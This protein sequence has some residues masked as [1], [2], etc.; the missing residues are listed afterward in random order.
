MAND[1]QLSGFKL[2][3]F[4]AESLSYL[5]EQLS[6]GNYYARSL[7]RLPFEEGMVLSNLPGILS[8]EEARDFNSSLFLRTNL[9]A[10]KASQTWLVSLIS[11]YL[12]GRDSSFAIFETLLEEGDKALIS[13]Q[14]HLFSHEK[15]IYLYLSESSPEIVLETLRHARGFPFVGG[16][17]TLPQSD[18]QFR[19]YEKVTY[20]IF[21]KLVERTDH[22]LVGGYDDE[23]YLVWQ[24]VAT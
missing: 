19:P 17:I 11:T 4:G 2:F 10:R 7:L 12:A 9:S 16:L 18:S 5:R 1:N 20:S 6:S 22:I 15:Q 24:R 14:S 23:G 21:D 13:I 3:Q 8:P